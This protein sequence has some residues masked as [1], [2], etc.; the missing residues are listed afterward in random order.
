MTI[1]VYRIINTI[2]QA[3][4]IGSSVCV[5]QRLRTHK[6][7]LLKNVHHNQKLIKRKMKSAQW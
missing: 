6:K 4:Y 2:T 7:D 1:G 3:S 5:E